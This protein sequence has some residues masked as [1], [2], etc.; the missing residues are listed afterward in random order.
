MIEI[1][2]H[3]DNHRLAEVLS[4]DEFMDP[5]RESLTEGLSDS[6]VASV[7]ECIL[8]SDSLR[9][10]AFEAGSEA[11]SEAGGESGAQAGQESGWEAG[12]EAA[13]EVQND[14]DG[15]ITWGDM[16][17]RLDSEFT[18]KS[19]QAGCGEWRSYFDAVDWAIKES[20]R[21]DVGTLHFLKDQADAASAGAHIEGDPIRITVNEGDTPGFTALAQR[22]QDL[23]LLV[24][25]LGIALQDSNTVLRTYA[26]TAAAHVWPAW[27]SGVSHR[28]RTN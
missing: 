27:M 24:S 11:G 3:I 26:D 10:A 15:S 18:G 25:G 23:E 9:E 6:L 1:T 21:N 13:H 12:R 16:T 2:A 20:I 14:G 17:S 19:M 7:T 8:E 28:I 22:V 4:T 5:I